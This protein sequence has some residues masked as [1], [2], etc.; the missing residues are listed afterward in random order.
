MLIF[1]GG[2]KLFVEM[3]VLIFWSK[4]F[5]I[6]DLKYKIDFLDISFTLTG[7]TKLSADLLVF[8]TGEEFGVNKSDI[9]KR[10]SLFLIW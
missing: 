1:K 2:L 8:T 6:L 9:S 5:K 4:S 3:E 7:S 10:E